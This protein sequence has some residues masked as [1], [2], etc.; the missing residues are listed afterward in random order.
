MNKNDKNS[1]IY[2]LEYIEKN[3][4]DLKIEWIDNYF[5]SEGFNISILLMNLSDN[6]RSF[7]KILQKSLNEE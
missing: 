5:I 3:K 1:F 2:S 7:Q 4:I 6:N